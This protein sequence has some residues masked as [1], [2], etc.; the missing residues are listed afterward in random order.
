MFLAV[1]V[2]FVCLAAFAYFF[3]FSSPPD[4]RDDGGIRQNK[5]GP[6]DGNFVEK[7]DETVEEET[8]PGGKMTLFFGSQ[9]GTAEEYAKI[10]AEE[11]KKNGFDTVVE[12]L[13]DI[14]VDNL[15]DKSSVGV[16]LFFM[17]TYGEGDPTDN[18]S[19]FDKWLTDKD[20]DLAED[21]LRGLR[22]AVFGLGNTQ[23]E[24]YNSMGKKVDRRLEQL[25]ADRLVKLGLGDDDQPNMDEQFEEWRIEAWPQIRA[26]ML[27]GA[28]AE[29]VQQSLSS[30]PDTAQIP[31]LDF[32][33]VWVRGTEPKNTPPPS[34]VDFSS[35][36]Y[37]RAVSAPVV[38]VRELRPGASAGAG[39]TVHVDIDIGAANLSYGTADN[40]A[41]CPINEPSVVDRAMELCGMPVEDDRH[42]VLRRR[43]GD[44]AKPQCIFPTPCTP[45]D[46]LAKYCDL[47]STVSKTLLPKLAAY[48]RDSEEQRELLELASPAGRDEFKKWVGDAKRTVL[49][50]MERY[51]SVT[52][53]FGDFVQIVPRLLAREYTIS[54]SSKRHPGVC[55]VTCKVVNEPKDSVGD[56]EH[57]GVCSTF[58]AGAET[59]SCVDIFVKP[60]TFN[61]PD[62]MSVP[63]I[64]VGP[65]TGVAPMRAFL[66]ERQ[67]IITE[68]EGQTSGL[69]EAILF[70]GCRR[71]E[72][73]FIYEEEMLGYT[74]DGT[75][76]E[77]HT[78][79]SRESAHRKIYVQDLM[80]EQASKIWQLVSRDKKPAHFYVCGGTSMGN[81][82]KKA[83][84]DVMVREGDMSSDA[85]YTMLKRMV[86]EGRYV[87]ELWS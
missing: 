87:A 83:L 59:R 44:A 24:H 40:L 62:D 48:A 34:E 66:Q 29:R 81:D 68:A 71:R 39:S 5:G 73:D 36:Q 35:K 60:S 57:H 78:A 65:G 7:N 69:G 76:T 6:T 18:A 10:M 21:T 55:S 31:D 33:L 38:D 70:F 63:I 37:F 22:Y 1:L 3:M 85:A 82:V 13:E 74:R 47:T 28:D 26:K 12:D 75:L 80:L 19:A 86:S 53:P 42:F 61:L 32:D 58:L 49:E 16:A 56:R 43:D 45:R 46:A 15:T 77:L 4:R 64:M 2:C 52:V 79:F 51:R 67:F 14:E 17:A 27:T 30:S 23:Y 41:V 9:T 8:Y 20:G 54:S 72:E 25:G 50:V 84:H 11:G